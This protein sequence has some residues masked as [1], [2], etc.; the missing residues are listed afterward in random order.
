MARHQEIIP[1]GTLE[2]GTAMSEGAAGK[3]LGA[4]ACSCAHSWGKGFG[5]QRLRPCLEDPQKRSSLRV[6]GGRAD[7]PSSEACHTGFSLHQPVQKGW[8]AH[9]DQEGTGFQEGIL[10]AMATAPPL[11]TLPAALPFC[12]V[13]RLASWDSVCRMCTALCGL[14]AYFCSQRWFC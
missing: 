11:T 2:Q 10:K 12:P 8:W 1:E 14:V 9:Q 5:Y 4:G 7:V 3:Q 13:A 6:W